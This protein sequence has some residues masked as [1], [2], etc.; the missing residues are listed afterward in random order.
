M[1]FW[2]PF[3]Y[4]YL[5]YVLCYTHVCS[6][7]CIAAIEASDEIVERVVT[8]SIALDDRQQ[9]IRTALEGVVNLAATLLMDCES[10]GAD[11]QGLPHPSI[12]TF[13][14]VNVSVVSS[15]ISFLNIMYIHK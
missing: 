13:T 8:S 2:V 9:D 10:S 3:H 4:D 12:F 14:T 1:L 5:S 11:C 15:C 7:T 6:C